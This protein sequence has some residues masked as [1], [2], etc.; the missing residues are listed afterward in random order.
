MDWELEVAYALMAGR[1]YQTNRASNGINWF[2]VPQGWVEFLHLPNNSQATNGGFE[3]SAFQ[4]ISD[5]KQIVISFAGTESSDISGD[6]I[7]DLVLA[8]GGL[9]SQ[10]QQAADYYLQIRA[11]NPDATITF[12]GHSLGGGLASLMAVFFGEGAYTFDQAPFLRSALTRTAFVDEK[13]I[14]RS[15]AQDLLTYLDGRGYDPERLQRDFPLPPAALAARHRS[16]KIELLK[17]NLR[18]RKGKSK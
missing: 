2:P 7:A 14:T 10:L 4:N 16:A 5:P 9:S 11:L 8:A 13:T 1:S 18:S 12:T 15:V 3:M 17:F 6:I